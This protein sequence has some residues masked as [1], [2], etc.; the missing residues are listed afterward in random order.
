MGFLGGIGRREVKELELMCEKKWSSATLG[1]K[2]REEAVEGIA[3]GWN[4]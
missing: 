3:L 2:W 4:K 1:K